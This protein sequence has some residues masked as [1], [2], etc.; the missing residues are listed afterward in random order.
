MEWNGAVV[1]F[2]D[3][4]DCPKQYTTRHQWTE[5]FGQRFVVESRHPSLT[6]LLEYSFD[7]QTAEY[8]YPM[9]AS[10]QETSSTSADR[11]SP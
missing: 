11:I 9:A 6:L 3:F 7:L 4:C 5:F 1:G 2:H 8:H 10:R